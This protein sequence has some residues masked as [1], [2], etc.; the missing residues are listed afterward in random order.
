MVVVGPKPILGRQETAL[1][2]QDELDQFRVGGLE[3]GGVGGEEHNGNLLDDRQGEDVVQVDQRGSKACQLQDA[4]PLEA[5]ARK[6]RTV[7]VTGPA[8]AGLAQR[9]GT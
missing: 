8:V 7:P 4:P 3:T 1:R 5:P 6:M 2:V 9:V